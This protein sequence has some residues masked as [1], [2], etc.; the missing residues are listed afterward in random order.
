[1]TFLLCAPLDFAYG[2]QEFCAAAKLDIDSMETKSEDNPELKAKLHSKA[3]YCSNC[4]TPHK[5]RKDF[6]GTEIHRNIKKHKVTF[7]D[8]EPNKAVADVKY[9]ESYKA[10]NARPVIREKETKKVACSCCIV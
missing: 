8:I 10:F 5:I 6:Y 4:P 2:E 3:T 9:V 7:K 1:M